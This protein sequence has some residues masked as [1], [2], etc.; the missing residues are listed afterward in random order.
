MAKGDFAESASLHASIGQR[1]FDELAIDGA[2][3]K[4]GDERIVV[5]P[6]ELLYG[7]VDLL[8]CRSHEASFSPAKSAGWSVATLPID[9]MFLTAC[10]K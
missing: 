9:F 4:E 8:H 2:P 1:Q 10:L 6:S 3:E 5:G 7:F